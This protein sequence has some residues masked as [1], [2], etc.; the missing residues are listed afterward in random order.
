MACGSCGKGPV[1]QIYGAQNVRTGLNPRA[2]TNGVYEMWHAR[3]CFTPYNGAF[4]NKSVYVVGLME[5]ELE[6]IFDRSDAKAAVV[7]AQDNRLSLHH[8]PAQNLCTDVMS[9]FFGG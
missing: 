6:K 8:L 9:V 4:R 5:G 2:G 7:Y 3:G 1:T